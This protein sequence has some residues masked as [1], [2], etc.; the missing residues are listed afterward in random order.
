MTSGAPRP[1]AA[2]LSTLGEAPLWD[3]RRGV[4]WWV[5]VR[6]PCLHGLEVASGAVRSIRMPEVIAALALRRGGGLLLCLRSGLWS[7]DPDGEAM[8]PLARRPDSEAGNRLNDTKV[9]AKGRLWTSTMWDFARQ[10]T[11][12]LYR[13][14]GDLAFHRMLGPVLI[15]N[16]ICFSPGRRYLPVERGGGLHHRCHACRRRRLVV[17]LVKLRDWDC[18]AFVALPRWPR[19]CR[20][21]WRRGGSLQPRRRWRS[22]RGV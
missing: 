5:D 19:V 3:H 20:S 4:L 17:V 12:A 6:S 10:R 22:W 16:A 18:P 21:A 7:F 2:P 15:P 1:V 8:A 11:G 14:D 13:V 9:D